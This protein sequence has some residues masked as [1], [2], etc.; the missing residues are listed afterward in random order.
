MKS[1]AV[2]GWWVAGRRLGISVTDLVGGR[3]DLALR[4][5]MCFR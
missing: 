1:I 3:P 5:T 2:S 4:M